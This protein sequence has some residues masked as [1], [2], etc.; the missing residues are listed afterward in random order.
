VTQ[1]SCFCPIRGI[2]KAWHFKF[3]VQI[4]RSKISEIGDNILEMVR[5]ENIQQQQTSS[6]KK[7]K[8]V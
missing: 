7:L 5:I 8:P 1:F 6:N 3:G 4:N 2:G